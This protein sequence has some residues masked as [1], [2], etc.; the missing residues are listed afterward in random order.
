MNQTRTS[1]SKISRAQDSKFDNYL[2]VATLGRQTLKK[3]IVKLRFVKWQ[4]EK[5]VFV[6]FAP[7]RGKDLPDWLQNA[8]SNHAQ[9]EIASES[10]AGK[11]TKIEVLIDQDGEKFY[12]KTAAQLF[13]EKYGKQIFTTH[14]Y[15]LDSHFVKIEYSPI[16]VE[17]YHYQSLEFDFQAEHYSDQI[18]QN[19]ISRWQREVTIQHL[20]KVF[21]KG[22]T[23]L[24]I[25]SGTGIETVQL[26]LG[27]LNIFATDISEKMLQILFER[28]RRLGV[29]ETIKSRVISSSQIAELAFD[30]N[31]PNG[32]FDGA[33]SSF[34][35]MN[36]ERN[37]RKFSKDLSGLLRPKSKV[38]FAVWNRFCISEMIA[39]VL[40]RDS[41]IERMSGYVKADEYS[42][43]SLDSYSYSRNEFIAQ[44]PEF[45]QVSCFALP[46]LIPPSEYSS[47][48]RSFLRFK[49]ADLA[50]GSLPILSR[51][52]DNFVITMRIK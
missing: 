27:G 52:G 12:F 49:R 33:F 48:V 23:I 7:S 37:L 46:T 32:G 19:P 39:R 36:L 26:A 16:P 28:A 13:A 5:S 24:E 38:V 51:I 25:G 31:L 40:K 11:I 21:D 34:G 8:I 42:R 29:Y 15:Y 14:S 10:F 22:Q 6:L 30:P 18:L 3:H 47:R 50:I 17:D 45:E 44:F 43:Y 9:S 35:V 2:Y 4:R 1:Q 41:S 20:L